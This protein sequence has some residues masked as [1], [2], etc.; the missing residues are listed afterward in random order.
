MKCS[1]KSKDGAILYSLTYKE[2]GKMV[3][4]N[5]ETGGGK[6]LL[7]LWSCRIVLGSQGIDQNDWHLHHRVCVVYTAL[8]FGEQVID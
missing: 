7:R 2:N 1:L 6:G 5:R 4:R 3:F 8:V